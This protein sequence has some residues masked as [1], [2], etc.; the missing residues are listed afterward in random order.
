MRARV[1]RDQVTVWLSATDTYWWTHRPDLSW[2]GSRLSGHRMV[3]VFDRNGLCDYSVDGVYGP[4]WEQRHGSIEAS[5]LNSMTA[6]FLSRRVPPHHPVFYVAVGQHLTDE[7][8]EAV[9]Q[10]QI[11][12]RLRGL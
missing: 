3:A 12:P 7:D 5:E 11:G 6:D 2:P 1:T 4:D 8:L 9:Y 10:A